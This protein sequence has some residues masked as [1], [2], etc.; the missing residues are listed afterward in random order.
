MKRRLFELLGI[1]SLL[2][3][4]V[5]ALAQGLYWA[6]FDIQRMEG[7]TLLGATVSP[8][9]NYTAFAYLNVEARD[10]QAVLVR[11]IDN[12]SGWERNVY[13]H[14]GCDEAE[15]LWLDDKTVVV[16]GQALYI[17]ED[18]YDSRHDNKVIN[19]RP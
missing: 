2:L 4:V 15:V 6:F 10:Q 13:W 5:S 3:L 17:T 8:K 1:I 11:V 14:V 7:Q 9:Q 18:I 12:R 19:T 16:N